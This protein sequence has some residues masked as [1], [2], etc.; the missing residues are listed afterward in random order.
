[1]AIT[2]PL[3]ILQSLDSRYRQNAS[4]LPVGRAV[5]EDWIGIGFRI[6]D[7]SLLTKMN[8]VSEILPPPPTIRVPGVKHWVKGLANVRGSLMPVLDMNAFLYGEATH[9]QKESRVLIINTLGVAAGLLVEEVYGLRRFKPEEH[10]NNA[11]ADMGSVGR[12][13]AGIFADQVWQWNVFSV[14]KLVKHDQ[15]IRVV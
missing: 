11:T 8:E 2:S 9:I 3:E 15:F 7:V 6:Q 13:L 12:Y 1:M 5:A 14:E 10:R 4:G